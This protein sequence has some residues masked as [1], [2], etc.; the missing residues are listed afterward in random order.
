MLS[1]V[2][3]C[4]KSQGQTLDRVLVDGRVPMFEHG[5][6]YV[7]AS[8]V[9]ERLEFGAFIDNTCSIKIWDASLQK[10]RDCLILQAITYEALLKPLHDMRATANA[11]YTGPAPVQYA[12]VAPALNE[13]VVLDNE[14]SLSTAGQQL[15]EDSSDDEWDWQLEITPDSVEEKLNRLF[16]FADHSVAFEDLLA[17]LNAPPSNDE[18]DSHVEKILSGMEAANKIMYRKGDGSSP[19]EMR[20]IHI[21]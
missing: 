20:R 19:D 7:A 21:I 17:A 13:P 9:H 5:M 2:D 12:Y 1:S 6:T 4:N 3:R 10:N 16:D 14:G 18:I 15:Q 8:R 11:Q